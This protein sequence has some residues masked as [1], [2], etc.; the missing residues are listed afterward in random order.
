VNPLR[1]L[2]TTRHNEMI[3]P[4]LQIWNY[5]IAI[6]LFLGGMVAG[7]MIILGFFLF[8][9]RHRELRCSC[10]VLP[11]LSIVL[12]SLGMLA[13]FLD[14]EDRW[15][16]WRLYVTFKP[17][18]PMSWGSW[19]LVLV[20]PALLAAMILRLP[21]SLKKVFPSL[22][23]LSNTAQGNQALVKFIGISN[24]ALGA[25]LGIYTGILLSAFGARPLW[26]SSL[27]GPLFLVSGLSTAAA[28]V[29][30]IAKD[31]HER[32]LL[33]KADNA[34]L[35]AEFFLIILF[36]VG[37]LSSTHSH[38]K[39]AHLILTG[40]FA[41]IFWV[42]VVGLGILVPLFIQSLAVSHRIPHTAIAPIMV[43]VGGLVLRLV[44]VYAGQASHWNMTAL[45]K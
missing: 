38:I 18:S 1:E 4:A 6:Y 8:K 17:A 31:P 14:L 28:F 42:F 44:M 40:P 30:L 21:D 12:L 45:P 19:I 23:T 39:S 34:F 35:S 27:L 13:L 7:M 20:Y 15:N 29:H 22:G 33:A 32:I 2:V 43:I 5:E 24:M 11:G 25:M 10:S 16:F 36:L 37:L 3:D 26:N 41:P 9:L